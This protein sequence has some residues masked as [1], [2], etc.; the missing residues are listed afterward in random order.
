MPGVYNQ[1]EVDVVGTIVGVVEHGQVIDGSR[2]APGDKI[3]GLASSG[4]HTNGYSLARKVVQG[5]DLRAPR[6]DLGGR[7]LGD[8]LLASHRSY[9]AEVRRLRAGDDGLAPVDIKGLA[10][11]TGGGLVD[12]PP[13]ILP[14]GTAMALGMGAWPLPPLFALL[15]R[16]G[17]IDDAELRH[18]FNVGLGMLVV[19]AAAEEA[20]AMSLLEAAGM[21]QSWQVGEVRDRK[22]GPA[23][24][25][26]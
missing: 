5:Q 10:H 17:G 1:G 3:I 6:E 14:D 9:L 2:I 24:V 13:R 20:R 16:L 12:N 8:A 11:I 19:V 15:Q 7:S 23:V 26:G 18:V 22:D 25:F 4:L 21:A